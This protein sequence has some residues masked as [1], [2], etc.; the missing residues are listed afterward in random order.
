M[1]R[2]L[3]RNEFYVYL[4]TDLVAFAQIVVFILT[5]LYARAVDSGTLPRFSYDIYILGYGR[6]LFEIVMALAFF[7]LVPL[8][9][10]ISRINRTHPE[11]PHGNK[12]LFI[13]CSKVFLAPAWLLA[14][15]WLAA[16]LLLQIGGGPG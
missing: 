6:L 13:T 5:F 8:A 11:R 14:F 9:F 3:G 16:V 4:A 15:F 7:L 10:R 1:K 2:L 12:R